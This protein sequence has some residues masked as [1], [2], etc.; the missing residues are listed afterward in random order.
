MTH[1]VQ[2]L[3]VDEMDLDAHKAVGVL[4]RDPVLRRC[5]Q[6]SSGD[7]FFQAYPVSYSRWHR[8]APQ[9]YPAFAKSSPF[10]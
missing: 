3:I 2:L 1:I 7:S 6:V 5:L 4:P 10:R 8:G 9:S